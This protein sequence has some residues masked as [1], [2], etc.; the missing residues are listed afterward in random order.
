MKAIIAEGVKNP[1][2]RLLKHRQRLCF[3]KGGFWKYYEIAFDREWLEKTGAL[4][5]QVQLEEIE[6]KK[7]P[8]KKQSV[9][10][11]GAIAK[12]PK[13]QPAKVPEKK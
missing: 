13:K 8:E 2:D 10:K 11:S 5:T 3:E 7:A 12:G 4:R 9:M 6:K 1:Q